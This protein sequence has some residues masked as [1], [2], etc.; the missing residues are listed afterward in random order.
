MYGENSGQLRNS[1][2]T[3]LGQYR[4]NSSLLREI[5]RATPSP[6]AE[7]QQIEAA[8]EVRRYRRTILTWCH[9][10]LVQ[11]DPNPKADRSPE[12][13]EPSDWLRRALERL[14][15]HNP[16]PLPSIAELTTPQN[17]GILETWRCAAKAAALA[18]HDFARGLGNGLLDHRE[19]LTLVGDVADITKALHVLDFRYRH[20]P[21]WERLKGVRGLDRHVD[22]CAS[23]SQARYGIPDYNIDWRGWHPPHPEIS[24]DADTITHVLAAEHRLVNSLKTVPSMANLR[25][26]LT[27]QRELSNL[28]T[29]R[30]RDIAPEQA[31]LFRRRE[32]N[33]GKISKAART[34]GGLAGTGASATQH[35]AD[36]VRLLI[37]IPVGEPIDVGAL[38]N[39]D[40]LFRHVDNTLHR[41]IEHGFNTRI[42]LVRNT[43]PRIDPTD[44]LQPHQARQIFY[45][46]QHEGRTPLVAVARRYLRSDPVRMTPPGFAAISRADFRDA[47]SHRR[48]TGRGIAM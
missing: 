38:R 3:L 5:S 30:A 42:Y 39:L 6:N 44:G 27:S 33:L 22:D 45:P 18:E 7:A 4:V 34:A 17:I 32:Q 19:W 9:Q 24:P 12:Q 31:A 25:H 43:L 11:A 13:Y 47:I 36:A 29:L 1:L 8:V 10:A 48:N 20:V 35:S 2:V 21:G 15:H 41:A 16:G 28:A 14:L 23:H 26:L 46:L 40:K 37:T